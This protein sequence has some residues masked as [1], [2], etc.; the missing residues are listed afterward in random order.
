MFPVTII[1][2]PSLLPA[3]RSDRR[4][5]DW[6][7][8]ETTYLSSA[9][10]LVSSDDYTFCL[11]RSPAVFLRDFVLRRQAPSSDSN[12][13]FNIKLQKP[14]DPLIILSL[15]KE[16]YFVRNR[17]FLPKNPQ[18]ASPNLSGFSPRLPTTESSPA[19][20]FHGFGSRPCQCVS[21][22][23][24][25]LGSSWFVRAPVPRGIMIVWA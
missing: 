22:P 13:R 19:T 8:N 10:F 16:T 17:Q 24:D 3:S 23:R 14:V 5:R 20:A 25:L 15:K 18:S 6:I 2:I 21:A 12:I 9:L 4:L 11:V 7:T 1:I